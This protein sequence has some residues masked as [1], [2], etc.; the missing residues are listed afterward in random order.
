MCGICGF[1]DFQGNL[2]DADAILRR[3]TGTLAH[4][5]PDGVGVFSDG[6]AGLGHTRLSI[7]DLAGGDQPLFNEDGSV[8]LVCNGE[9]YNYKDL[10]R[11]LSRKGH[12]F[13]TAS[14]SEVVLHLWEEAGAGCV[15]ELR[16]MFAFALYDSRKRVMFGARDRFGQKPFFYHGQGNI[17]S[18][19]SEIKALLT[20]PHIRP[21]LN[22]AAS[23]QFLFYGYI[24]HPNTLFK[25]VHQL[26]PAHFFQADQSGLKIER[27]WR[28]RFSPPDREQSDSEYLEQLK[29]DVADAVRSH[30]V[31]DVPVGIFLSGGIDSSLVAALAAG[32]DSKPLKSFSIA[33]P[34]H[35][36]D[37]SRYARMASDLL[38]TEHHE[39][40]YSPDHIETS[41]DNM[42]RIFDQPLADPAALPLSFLSE[43]AS[44]HVK[45]VLTG[46]GGDELFAGYG[47]YR[48]AEKESALREW[49]IRRFP[50]LFSLRELARCAPDP[51]QLRRL[52][53]RT[54][55]RLLPTSQCLYSKNG[56]EG[57][58][59]HRL[60][61]EEFRNQLSDAFDPVTPDLSDGH[62]DATALKT[63]LR[64][65]QNRYLPDD[66]L[67]KTDY[68]TMAYGLE[69]RAPFLDHH[70]AVT[71][72]S[73]PDHLLADR[74]ETK[75]AL[76]RIASELLPRELVQRPK[77]GFSVPIKKWFRE[78]L[79]DW[80]AGLLLDGAAT[81]PR[82]FR[83]DTVKAVL[84]AHASGR[85]NHTRKIFILVVFELW[86]RHYLP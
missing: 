60:Y 53:S 70:L 64:I 14:D 26:P 8:A 35:R 4:R 20:L 22:P 77:R 38:G 12:R 69:A 66:L 48:E 2:S 76:R 68:S 7:I 3:M 62:G 61:S 43:Q 33:Y 73:L 52:R 44:R 32:T 13:R 30:L 45:V 40:A 23:D 1:L 17:F 82:Y 78:E 74:N 19:A 24:P 31:S 6:S 46:D 55:L 72:A 47:K 79:K 71:A 49:I 29:A 28:N 83:R 85:Q 56:W 80:T 59:R 84:D 51:F 58:H 41:I 81:V 18:F 15:E 39:F 5:G 9:I 42:V 36:Y 67:L 16:G 37:E 57:W 25:G 27:Y 11:R 34:G 86:H 21:E 63:M 54:A 10:R 75:I 50:G 65:D